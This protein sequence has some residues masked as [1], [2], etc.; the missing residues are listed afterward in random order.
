MMN[1]NQRSDCIIAQS[2]RSKFLEEIAFITLMYFQ[3]GRY[4]DKMITWSFL[5]LILECI[6]Y[7]NGDCVA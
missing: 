5:L 6:C 1:S 7:E 3:A 4:D 2:S